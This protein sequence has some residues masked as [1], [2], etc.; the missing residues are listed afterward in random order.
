M[1]PTIH[2]ISTGKQTKEEFSE[3]TRIIHEYVDF[4]HIREKSRT[5]LEV[6]E[7]VETLIGKGVPLRKII[8]N[9]R[10]DVAEVTD[11][12]G[13]Q[14]AYH[15]LSVHHVKKNFPN[16]RIGKSVHSVDEAIIAEKQGADYL[17][18]GHL[19][20]TASKPDLFPRGVSQLKQLTEQVNIPVIGIGGITP[21]HSPHVFRAGASGIAVMSGILQADD[22]LADVKEYRNRIEEVQYGAEL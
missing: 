13:V 17:L 19:F 16:L 5:A 7:I 20:H 1:K 11:V 18:F 2:V 4:I 6:A 8:I 22:P 12:Y 10:V 9:D 15:S 14:L 21:H 3:I